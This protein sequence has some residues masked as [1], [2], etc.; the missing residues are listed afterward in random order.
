[1]PYTAC[2]VGAVF[3][4]NKNQVLREPSFI[5]HQC[6]QESRVFTTIYK[7]FTVIKAALM[8]VSIIFSRS[9]TGILWLHFH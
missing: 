7:L 6:V 9:N 2:T 4:A 5:G 3:G 8:K 1:M